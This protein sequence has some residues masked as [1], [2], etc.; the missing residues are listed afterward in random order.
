[1]I[2]NFLIYCGQP[3][4]QMIPMPPVNL[5]VDADHSCN[6]WKCCF[7]CRC[8]KKIKV[9]DDS[10]VSVEITEKITRTFERHHHS[11]QD[12]GVIVPVLP[13]SP[14]LLRAVHFKKTDEIEGQ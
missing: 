5:D 6:N 12:I 4:V 14:R 1:M 9:V 13:A 11:H 10:P 3:E 2:N 8:F 7:G